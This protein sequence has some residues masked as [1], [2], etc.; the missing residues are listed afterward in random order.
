MSTT[1]QALQLAE[2]GADRLAWRAAEYHLIELARNGR[3]FTSDALLDY[4]DE[5]NHY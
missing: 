5:H 2:S 3:P 1:Q 4:L